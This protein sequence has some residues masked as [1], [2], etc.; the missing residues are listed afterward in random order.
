MQC[1]L[2]KVL[3]THVT[4][5]QSNVL[6]SIK[7]ANEDMTYVAAQKWYKIKIRIADLYVL[8]IKLY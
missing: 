6:P 7:K 4:N 8:I 3:V 1:L 2:W 5:Y